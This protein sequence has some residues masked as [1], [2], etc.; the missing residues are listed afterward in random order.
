MRVEHRGDSLMATRLKSK[1]PL[2][3]LATY[4]VDDLK[5]ALTEVVAE[6]A[7]EHANLCAA[8]IRPRPLSEAEM[9]LLQTERQNLTT[10]DLAKYRI[11]YWEGVEDRLWNW[12]KV[13]SGQATGLGNQGGS[14]LG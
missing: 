1:D 11:K 4:S 10:V 5:Q 13:R 9:K 8:E 6:L 3:F 12:Y 7:R 14:S 2:A